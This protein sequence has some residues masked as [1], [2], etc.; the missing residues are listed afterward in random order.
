ML[1]EHFTN[2][3]GRVAQLSREAMETYCWTH[4]PILPLI[5]AGCVG[6]VG[7]AL[8]AAVIAIL[9]SKRRAA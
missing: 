3:A 9:V 6:A 7:G 5:I 1:K 8:F 2:T 4:P